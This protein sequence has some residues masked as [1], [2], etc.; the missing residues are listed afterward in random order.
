MHVHT[1]VVLMCLKIYINFNGKYIHYTYICTHKDMHTHTCTHTQ[2][3]TQ[4]HAHA[5]THKAKQSK[6]KCF[7]AA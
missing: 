4:T 3:H 1:N 5:R 2:I 6:A 7:A